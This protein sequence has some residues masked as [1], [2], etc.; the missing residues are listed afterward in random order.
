[1]TTIYSIELKDRLLLKEI[2][3]CFQ[4]VKEYQEFFKF[5]PTLSKSFDLRIFKTE[6]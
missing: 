3:I 6:I 5:I 1:M 4:D 2:T